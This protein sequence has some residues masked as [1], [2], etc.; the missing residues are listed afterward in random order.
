[1]LNNF[2][3]AQTKDLFLEALGAGNI[4]DEAIV[5][6]EDT[7][8]IWNHGHYFGGG[9]SIVDSAPETYDAPFSTNDLLDVKDGIETEIEAN[10]DE[11]KQAIIDKKLIIFTND[12]GVTVA[13][14]RYNS[15]KGKVF[16]TVINHNGVAIYIM[17]NDGDTELTAENIEVFD[18]GDIDYRL[19]LLEEDIPAAVTESTVSDWGFTKNTGTYSKPSTGIPKTDLASAVQ[20]SLGKAD[21]AL[22]SHQD[23]SGKQDKLVSGTNIKTINGASILGSGD[24]TISGGGSSSGNGA[25]SEVNHGTSDTTFTLTPN[26][27]HV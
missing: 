2:I 1:M 5:F 17:W 10:L 13:S 25:Y 18:V 16:L 22:Q 11:L 6:I 21:T 14:A 3:Y 26:T 20:T 15:K 27:F 24:I 19:G 7:K 4:L 23:I 9:A 12:G 8:E